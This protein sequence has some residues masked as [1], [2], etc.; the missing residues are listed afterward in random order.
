[1]LQ[2][3]YSLCMCTPLE[4]QVKHHSDVPGPVQGGV[5]LFSCYDRGVGPNCSGANASTTIVRFSGADMRKIFSNVS[6]TYRQ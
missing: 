2:P 4:S 5:H 6:Y 3:N 1:M